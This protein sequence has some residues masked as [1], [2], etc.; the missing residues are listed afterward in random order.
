MK[1]GFAV[2]VGRSN[3]GKSTLLNALIG[4]KVA[5][6]TPKAQTTRM[7]IQGIATDERGQIVFV[8]TPGIMQKA[9][10]PLT[11][12]LMHYANDA[13]K[14]VD[15]VVYVVDPTRSIG[16]EEHKALQMIETIT[17]PKILVINKIDEYNKPF[18]ES[19]HALADRFDVMVEVSA[20]RGKNIKALKNQIFE[21]LHEG[22]F[23]YPD[24]QLSNMSQDRWVAE[25]I[26]EKLFLRLH[27]EVPYAIHVEV[28]EVTIRPDDSIF[29]SA[30]ILTNAERYKSMIIGAGGRGIKEIGSSVRKELEGVADRKVFLELHVETDPHW[31][32]RL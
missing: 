31:L 29:I 19:Y 24:A 4:S 32:G 26:R 25:I 9:R 2:L 16:N 18:L 14:D 27:D 6:T 3:V 10:D 11:K 12:R 13:L 5:I 30:R 8:D 23:F 1:S 7:P 28:D 17:K 21:F 22:E 20:L 15:V